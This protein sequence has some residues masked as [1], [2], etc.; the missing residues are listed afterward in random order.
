LDLTHRV[1]KECLD[2]LGGRGAS[3]GEPANL[4]RD[5][6][7]TPV[8]ITGAC[9]FKGCVDERDVGLQGD[10]IKA[11]GHAAIWVAGLSWPAS[12]FAQRC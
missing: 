3:L 6:P 5:D 9:R 11:P 2:L 8:S 12:P 10:A 7:N 4:G 1:A